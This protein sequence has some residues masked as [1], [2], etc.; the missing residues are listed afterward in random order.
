MP[1]P[2]MDSWHSSSVISGTGKKEGES[3]L[4]LGMVLWW[5]YHQSENPTVRTSKKEESL[6]IGLAH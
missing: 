4:K 3:A 6:A 1:N 5:I 2:L